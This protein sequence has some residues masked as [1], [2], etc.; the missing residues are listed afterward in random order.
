[1]PGHTV[2][3]M[4]VRDLREADRRVLADTAA[5][6]AQVRADQLDLPTPCAGWSVRDLLRH[7][8]GNNDGFAAAARGAAPDAAV[9]D[10]VGVTDPVGE[11]APSAAR[12]AEAFAAVEP[13]TG[14]FAV[15]G[16]G[17]VP[18]GQ[19][20]GMH[21]IDY[22]VHGWD[23]AVSIGADPGLDEEHCAAVLR[24]GAGWPLDSPAIWG[25]G[26]A[27]G[28]RVEVPADAPVADRMLGFLGR[29]PR[30]PD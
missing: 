11:F 26:A 16:Y 23:V 29:S 25:P 19:A 6:V 18:A 10:G 3:T 5:I 15:L 21:F 12:V 14:R 8:A 27:F 24:I 7:M 13:L 28:H 4:D 17:A 2:V 22:L 20:V 1:M 30:W 9:W